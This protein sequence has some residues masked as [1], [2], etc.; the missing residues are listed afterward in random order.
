LNRKFSEG[1]YISHLFLIVFVVNFASKDSS[2]TSDQKLD[3]KTAT[4]SQSLNELTFSEE[5]DLFKTK[6]VDENDGKFATI[7]TNLLKKYSISTVNVASMP[8]SNSIGA[9]I[10]RKI[11][12]SN[13]SIDD[14]KK[15]FLKEPKQQQQQ[16]VTNLSSLRFKFK[17]LKK[18][19]ISGPVNFQ[20]LTHIDQPVPIGRRYKLNYKS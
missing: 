15:R 2:E 1:D 20:H 12:G 11:F 13:S 9:I 10:K 17:K 8:N 14:L 5:T 16:S 4:L 6:F 7:R 3:V 18:S 19:D